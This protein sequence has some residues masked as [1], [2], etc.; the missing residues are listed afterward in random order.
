MDGIQRGEIWWADLPEP[1][2]SESGDRRPVLVV[3]ADSFNASR[4]QTAIV[5]T[6]T[7]NLELAGTLPSRLQRSVDGIR[8]LH[9]L[10]P[11]V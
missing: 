9:S 8:V 11:V 5:A 1:H 10:R 3:Q 2:R 6:I 7:S 4:I